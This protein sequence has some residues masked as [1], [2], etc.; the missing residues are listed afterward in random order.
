MFLEIYF[1]VSDDSGKWVKAETTWYED[2][3]KP[4]V[5]AVDLDERP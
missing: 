4:W 3:S 1:L 2:E 5:H